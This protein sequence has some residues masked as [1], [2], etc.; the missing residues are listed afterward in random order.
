MIRCE[1][2]AESYVLSYHK[3]LSVAIE[4]ICFGLRVFYVLWRLKETGFSTRLRVVISSSRPICERESDRGERERDREKHG[5]IMISVFFL[6][7]TL[8]IFTQILK[9]NE[10]VHMHWGAKAFN[11]YHCIPYRIA[12]R[13]QLKIRRSFYFTH[14]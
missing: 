2:Q 4:N 12:N 5:K 10:Y 8:N 7:Y 9:I 14:F 11:F 13:W 6:F 1:F 3:S